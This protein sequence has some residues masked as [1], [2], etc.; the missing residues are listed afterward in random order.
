M[1]RKRIYIISVY[2]YDTP[3]FGYAIPWFFIDTHKRVTNLGKTRSN[4]ERGGCYLESL[5]L[6]ISSRKGMNQH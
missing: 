6:K 1:Q 2:D 4:T 5:Y 3:M